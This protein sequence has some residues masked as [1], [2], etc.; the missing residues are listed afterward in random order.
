MYKRTY[1]K[2]HVV[3]QG[4]TVIQQG[5]LQDQ[6]HFNNLEL[7][8]SDAHLAQAI[9]Q[10]GD[11]QNGF[12][13]AAEVKQVTLTGSGAWPFNNSEYTVGLDGL[14]NTTNY[15]VDVYVR[16]YSG[17]LLGDIIVSN[18]ALNGFKI[19]H[20]GSANT[21]NLTLVVRGGMTV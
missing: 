4:G 13:D 19:K 1:W 20:D 2:D 17:G 15:T 10:I 3:D 16:S 7:G 11:N 6:E 5:T 14:R 18:K 21:V 12:E 8:M 9:L